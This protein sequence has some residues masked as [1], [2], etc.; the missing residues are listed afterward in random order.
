MNGGC[1]D[2]EIRPFTDVTDPQKPP[3]FTWAA[4]PSMPMNNPQASVY[5]YSHTTSDQESIT[6]HYTLF[7]IMTAADAIRWV[8]DHRSDSIPS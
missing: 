3:A 6:M 4:T 8:E 2:G 5:K 1:F 7:Q